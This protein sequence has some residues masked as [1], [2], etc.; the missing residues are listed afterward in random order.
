[1]DKLETITLETMPK[2]RLDDV[3]EAI[4]RSAPAIN[5]VTFSDVMRHT[6]PDVVADWVIVECGNQS[7]R[8]LINK[9][10]EPQTDAELIDLLRASS[11]GGS[12]L[13][14]D[15]LKGMIWSHVA[16]DLADKARKARALVRDDERFAAEWDA[17]AAG[18]IRTPA[19]SSDQRAIAREWSR[20]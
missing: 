5:A 1:M 8:D 17:A 15:K 13:V 7:P 18:L 20:R 9:I 2:A 19:P 4:A 14:G 3:V 16:H 12:V 10:L 6:T 11:R